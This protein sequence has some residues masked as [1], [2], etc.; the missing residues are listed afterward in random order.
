VNPNAAFDP[1]LL[2]L[3]AAAVSGLFL[4][5]RRQGTAD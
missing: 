1:G 5:R 2:G 3:L 4:R